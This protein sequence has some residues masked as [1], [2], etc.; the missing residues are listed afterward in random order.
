MSRFRPVFGGEPFSEPGAR[1]CVDTEVAC[2]GS[3]ACRPAAL[4]KSGVLAYTESHKS[5]MIQ[6]VG[7]LP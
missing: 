3:C 5:V 4:A 6:R 1:E 2:V 7:R